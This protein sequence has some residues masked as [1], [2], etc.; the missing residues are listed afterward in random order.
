MLLVA[1]QILTFIAI[2][3]IV[4][5]H[6]KHGSSVPWLCYLGVYVVVFKQMNAKIRKACLKEQW[7]IQ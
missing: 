4:E 5:C 6:F 1:P 7:L 2:P 3:E